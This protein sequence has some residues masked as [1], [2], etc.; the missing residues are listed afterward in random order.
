MV[1]L[2][3]QLDQGIINI[4]GTKLTNNTLVRFATK[5]WTNAVGRRP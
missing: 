1:A 5:T 4:N 2:G 3:Y